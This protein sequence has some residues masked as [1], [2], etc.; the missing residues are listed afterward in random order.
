[1][2]TGEHLP[3]CFLQQQTGRWRPTQSLSEE[4][5]GKSGSA[6]LRTGPS[7]NYWE[8]DIGKVWLPVP[9]LPC[10]QSDIVTAPSGKGDV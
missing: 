8:G 6:I 1:M 7:S 2:C 10:L 5:E 9:Q 3:S 4:A